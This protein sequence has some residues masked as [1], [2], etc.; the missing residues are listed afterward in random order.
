MLA[1]EGSDYQQHYIKKNEFIIETASNCVQLD[2]R[3]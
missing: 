2:D 3:E 1:S